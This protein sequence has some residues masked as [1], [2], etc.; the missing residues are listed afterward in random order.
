MGD[1]LGVSSRN[2]AVLILAQTIRPVLYGLLAGAGLAAS[3]AIALLSMPAGAMI[4]QVIRVTDPIAYAGS[5]LAIVVA[6][7]LA[8]WLPATRAARLDPMQAIRHD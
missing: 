7:L 3:L 1:A 4:A 8:A 2:V 6:C 5:V